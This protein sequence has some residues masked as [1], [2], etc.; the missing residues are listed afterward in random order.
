MSVDPRT[1]PA[2]SLESDLAEL[3]AALARLPLP[4]LAD[5]V[6]AALVA[7]HAPMRLLWRVGN[8]C[9]SH[10]YTSLDEI[11]SDVVRPRPAGTSAPAR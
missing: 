10:L 6:L 2:S 11:C 1:T 7:R 3:R 4:A 8:L 5:D 9:R